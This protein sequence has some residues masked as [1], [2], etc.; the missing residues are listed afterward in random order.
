[1]V[2]LGAGVVLVGLAA[3]HVTIQQDIWAG[4]L[5]GDGLSRMLPRPQFTDSARKNRHV[6]ELFDRDRASCRARFVRIL[7]SLIRSGNTG[8]RA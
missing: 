1:M 2:A 7:T 5:R 3:T 8:R 6:R 4:L